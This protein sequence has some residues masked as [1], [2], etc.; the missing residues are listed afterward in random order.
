MALQVD[1]ALPAVHGFAVAGVL[2]PGPDA[3]LL[4]VTIER[5][6]LVWA[7]ARGARRDGMLAGWLAETLPA[8]CGELFTRAGVPMLPFVP[9][10]VVEAAHMLLAATPPLTSPN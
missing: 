6:L 3:R 8:A 4:L 1:V 10:L 7:D 9:A 2:L 5:D